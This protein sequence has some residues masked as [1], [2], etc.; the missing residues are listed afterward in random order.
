MLECNNNISYSLTFSPLLVS[1]SSFSPAMIN[2]AAAYFGSTKAQVYI[3]KKETFPQV[4]KICDDWGNRK[5]GRECRRGN[6]FNVSCNH[7]KCEIRHVLMEL[8]VEVLST[9]MSGVILHLAALSRFSWKLSTGLL[10][11]RCSWDSDYICLFLPGCVRQG[12]ARQSAGVSK[13]LDSTLIIILDQW[14]I[15]ENSINGFVT[16]CSG[17]FVSS[18]WELSNSSEGGAQELSIVSWT[19]MCEYDHSRTCVDVFAVSGARDPP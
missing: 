8:T 7:D 17:A 2:V 5:G 14:K 10:T 4:K 12:E 6:G 9:H 15:N 19:H 3:I 16:S 1:L 18:S 11:K 13:F